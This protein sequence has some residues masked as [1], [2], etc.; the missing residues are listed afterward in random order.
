[1]STAPTHYITP[2][3][4]LE[5]ERRADFRSEYTGGEV[6][7]MA[8]GTSSHNRITGNILSALRPQLRGKSC[9]VY[10]NDM[11]VWIPDFAEFTYPD[12]ALVCGEEQ[13]RDQ[14]RDVLLNPV[15]LVE[16]LS[17]TTSSYDR[18]E[19]FEKYRRISSFHE[20]ILVAQDRAR[21]EHYQWMDGGR[22]MLTFYTDLHSAVTFAS[23][24][25]ALR[26]ADVYED[27]QFA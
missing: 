27:V 22:W 3:E 17:P 8:G 9:F 13:F 21:V 24:P 25:V 15:L 5:Q 11:K 18:G 16:V 7:A 26:L 20:Y 2:E 19:K 4:Y 14:K 12:L 6:F 1:M 23:V 10:A